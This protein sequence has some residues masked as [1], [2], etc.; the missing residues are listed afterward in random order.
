MGKSTISIAMFNS[1]VSLPTISM[2][3]F[4]FAIYVCLLNGRVTH[5]DGA[6]MNL[7]QKHSEKLGH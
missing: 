1:Y 7:A 4:Q 3:I 6:I 2:A 5:H